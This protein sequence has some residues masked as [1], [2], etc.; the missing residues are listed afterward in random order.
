MSDG[1]ARDTTPPALA[2][3]PDAPTRS[4]EW[5]LSTASLHDLR[6]FKFCY[7]SPDNS[8]S[9]CTGILLFYHND[10]QDA[11]G[12]IFRERLTSR[13]ILRRNAQYRNVKV[14][15]TY[16]VEWKVVGLPLE[17]INNS[18]GDDSWRS[19][20]ETG[21]IRWW[22]GRLGN[23]IVIDSDHQTRY[24]PLNWLHL[25]L[26]TPRLLHRQD[27]FQY[28][29]P[30]LLNIRLPRRAVQ[31]LHLCGRLAEISSYGQMPVVSCVPR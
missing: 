27:Q 23:Q 22:F 25:A 31:A 7:D 17:H 30:R 29:Y 8:S 3:F 15:N 14:K 10:I 21:T 24:Y 18:D 9:S 6:S 16:Y 26:D 5:Y 4:W 13:E 19:V 11:L 20:P 2:A 12:Q 1:L 28:S